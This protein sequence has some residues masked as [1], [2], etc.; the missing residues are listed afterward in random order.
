MPE[1]EF[2]RLARL[3][4]KWWYNTYKFQ[5]PS[6]IYIVWE[7][8]VLQNNKAMLSTNIPDHMYFEVTYNGDKEELY[9]DAYEKQLNQAFGHTSELDG[10]YPKEEN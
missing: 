8:K 1:K 10:I 5:D 6:E 7:V 4:V 3:A 9:F 2:T